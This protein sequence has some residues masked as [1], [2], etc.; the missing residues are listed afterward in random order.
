VQAALPQWSPEAYEKVR[1]MA[2]QQAM[3]VRM[4]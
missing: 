3:K 4:N 2:I 1:A